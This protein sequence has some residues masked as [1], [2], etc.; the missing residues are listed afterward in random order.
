[1][2]KLG[3]N[4]AEKITELRKAL[5]ASQEENAM[6]KRLAMLNIQA[7]FGR[8]KASVRTSETGTTTKA[9]A[10]LRQVTPVR[11]LLAENFGGL[12]MVKLGQALD[13]AKVAFYNVA[14][15]HWP[16]VFS[17]FSGSH[18]LVS[19]GGREL[20]VYKYKI[21][22]YYRDIKAVPDAIFFGRAMNS[23]SIA[24]NVFARANA[25]DVT[26]PDRLDNYLLYCQSAT[27]ALGDDERTKAIRAIRDEVVA[28]V[29]EI[30]KSALIAKVFEEELP[31]WNEVPIIRVERYLPP[32]RG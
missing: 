14:E 9:W 13:L 30:Q 8:G 2:V 17:R 25:Y 24:R 31:F 28:E 29:R 6:P 32:D 26:S 5:Q 18:H 3:G 1:M 23:V 12:G 10:I 7:R 27:C 4:G 15:A 16:C 19:F 21:D 20:E 11:Q 22:R